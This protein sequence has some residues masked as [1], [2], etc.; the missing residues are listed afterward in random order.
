[1]DPSMTRKRLLLVGWDSADWKLINPLM[2]AGTM[3]VLEG[4]VNS[5]TSGN[6]TTVEPQLSPMLRT[7]IATGKMAY[8]HGVPGFTEVEPQSGTVVPVSAATRKCKILGS[9]SLSG[10]PKATSSVGSRPKGNGT[11]PAKW[12]RTCTVTSPTSRPF[13]IPRIGPL[14]HREPIGRMISRHSSTK[15]ALPCPDAC[16][17]R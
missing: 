1:M 10:D 17:R 4:L 6:L 13:R 9:C 11:F 12:S 15:T 8:H 5:G 3:P 7:S 16:P 14:H 2:D